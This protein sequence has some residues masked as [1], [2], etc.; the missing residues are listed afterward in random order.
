MNIINNIREAQEEKRQ[1]IA[2][3]YVS[4]ALKIDRENLL[5]FFKG[6]RA[7]E[8]ESIL[9]SLEN[10]K[11]DKPWPKGT[12]NNDAF[13]LAVQEAISIVKSVLRD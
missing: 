8:R 4:D 1:E 11:Y 10:I 13:D 7:G 5:T 6:T 12:S 2:R 3:P 9:L